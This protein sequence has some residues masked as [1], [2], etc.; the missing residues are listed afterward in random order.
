[1]NIATWGRVC[2]ATNRRL[3]VIC[4]LV[5]TSVMTASAIAAHAA[6]AIQVLV[7]TSV[8]PCQLSWIH[9]MESTPRLYHRP[10]AGSS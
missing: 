6:H 9:P 10:V 3:R 4:R 1:M 2:S 8:I 7:P 5:K